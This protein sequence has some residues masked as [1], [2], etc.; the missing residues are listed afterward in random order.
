MRKLA[1]L[2]ILLLTGCATTYSPYGAGRG[3]AIGHLLVADRLPP[4]A[5]EAVEETYDALSE[6][7]DQYQ[8]GGL[9][10]I[11][12]QV[13]GILASRLDGEKLML[14]LVALS[15]YWPVVEDAVSGG[16][17]VVEALEE[18]RAGV[19]SIYGEGGK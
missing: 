3:V 11:H 5:R 15:R 7:L 2:S 12:E 9:D 16:A 1:L 19:R 8:G 17:P 10:A 4:E 18:F 6:A 13:E 14:A